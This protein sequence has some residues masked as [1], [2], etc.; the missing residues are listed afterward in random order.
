MVLRAGRIAAGV[1][2]LASALLLRVGGVS[3]IG[4]VTSPVCGGVEDAPALPPGVAIAGAG[5]RTAKLLSESEDPYRK[6]RY[7]RKMLSFSTSA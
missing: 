5:I 6:L 7:L 3:M 1:I 4:G 2:P